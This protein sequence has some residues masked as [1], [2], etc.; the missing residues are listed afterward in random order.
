MGWFT[1]KRDEQWRDDAQKLGRLKYTLSKLNPSD[2]GY[3]NIQKTV[4][5]LEKRLRKQVGKRNYGNI[6]APAINGYFN[7]EKRKGN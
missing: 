1:S 7:L 6:V 2:H 3:E 5:S 4:N